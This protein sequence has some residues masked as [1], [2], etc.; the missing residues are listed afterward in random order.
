MASAS[1]KEGCDKLINKISFSYKKMVT[2]RKANISDSGE[3]FKLEKAWEKEKIN[4]G[5]FLPKDREKELVK[6]LRRNIFY[7]A[8]ENGMILGFIEGEIIKAKRMKPSFEIKKGERYGELHAVY[9]LKKFRGKK[10][11]KLLIDRLFEDFSK[12]KVKRIVLK[13]TSKDA[14][15]LV[16]YYKKLGFEERLV[17]MVLKC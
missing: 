12:E 11:G 15:G 16:N 14:W 3:I 13:S 1:N 9:V 7:V 10:I 17:D 8:E 6:E 4:W 2:I 5:I